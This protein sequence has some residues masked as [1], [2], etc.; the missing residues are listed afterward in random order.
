MEAWAFVFLDIDCDH[1]R[2][3]NDCLGHDADDAALVG[4][5]ARPIWVAKLRTLTTRNYD[6][7]QNLPP[8]VR[9]DMLV[10]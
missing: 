9:E 7:M 4:V 6:T 3:I 1:F 5:A 2:K 8:N 10:F